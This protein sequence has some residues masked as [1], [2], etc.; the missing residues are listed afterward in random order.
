MDQ[1][2][3]IGRNNNR[4]EWSE[5]E[6]RD[7]RGC[8]S[9]VHCLRQVFFQRLTFVY[10]LSIPRSSRWAPRPRHLLHTLSSLSAS[11]HTLFSLPA[12]ISKANK[13]CSCTSTRTHQ[14]DLHSSLSRHRTRAARSKHITGR[15]SRI[16]EYSLSLRTR[17]TR[18]DSAR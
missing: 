18:S 7:R 9:S 1:D 2:S 12:S 10:T 17:F 8:V 4:E 13:D 16:I 3:L 14:L 5:R 6:E 11:S 15:P